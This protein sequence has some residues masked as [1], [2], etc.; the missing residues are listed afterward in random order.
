MDSL[1]SVAHLQREIGDDLFATLI[2][3]DNTAAVRR[4]AEELRKSGPPMSMTVGG[5]TYDILGFLEDGEGCVNGLFMVH[6]ARNRKMSA[7]LGK[8]EWEHILAHQDEIPVDLRDKV[9]FAFTDDRDGQS[10]YQDITCIWWHRDQWVLGKRHLSEDW[11]DTYRVL[12]R[13]PA[14]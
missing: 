5:R 14:R 4:F 6:R 12:R 3:S 13:K 7:H 9:S 11:D 2:N 8:E 1:H 10:P